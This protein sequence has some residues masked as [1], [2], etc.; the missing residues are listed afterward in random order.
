MKQQLGWVV[1]LGLPLWALTQ[2]M[3]F[4]ACA[5]LLNAFIQVSPL[6]SPSRI[7]YLNILSKI[8]PL[9]LARVAQLVGALSHELK[10]CGFKP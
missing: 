1:N 6:V 5:F 9:A 2:L 10:G 3:P 7:C 4:W 8:M